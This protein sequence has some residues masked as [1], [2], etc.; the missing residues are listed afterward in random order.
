MLKPS[1]IFDLRKVMEEK[2]GFIPLTAE[3]EAQQLILES[4]VVVTKGDYPEIKKIGKDIKVLD[5]HK[6]LEFLLSKFNAIVRYNRMTRRREVN[7]PH[8]YHFQDDSDNDMLARIEYLATLNEMPNKQIDK[9]LDM[10]AGENAYHPI[11]ECI[12]SNPWDNVPRLDNF[13]NTLETNNPAQDKRVIKTWMMAAMKAA[14]SIE[15]FTN[16]GVLVLQGKQ[17]IGKTEWAKSLDPLDCNAVKVGALIDPRNKDSI[18]G[19]NRFWIAELGELDAT[20]NKTDIAHLKSFITSSADDI[21]VPWGRKETRFARRTAYIATVND[22]SFLVDSTGNRRWWTI[23]VISINYQHNFNMIQ[24]W[25]EVKYLL[26][27]GALTYLPN[28]LQEKVNVTNEAHEK[29]DPIKEKLLTWYDWSDTYRKELTATAVLEELGYIKPNREEATKMG[30]F[31]KEQNNNTEGR[32]SNGVKLHKVPCKI[33]WR[34]EI[35]K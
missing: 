31:L 18:I 5:T 24:V 27:N 9:F 13:I 8:K 26:D 33:L 11:V 1:N 30:R 16:H 29:L 32:K 7:I 20:L 35:M 28:E 10:L 15:G 19:L 2:D 23:E 22:T 3:Q 12:N 21:R 17:G 6:N 4:N 25:A 34:N 14:Y